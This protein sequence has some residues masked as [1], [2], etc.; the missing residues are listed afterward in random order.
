MRHPI[1]KDRSSKYTLNISQYL[2]LSLSLSVS[3]SV[4]LS[5]CLSVSL[6]L[7]LC[8]Y[9]NFIQMNT[10]ENMIE[11]EEEASSSTSVE[12]RPT[13]HPM[14]NFGGL[15]LSRFANEDMVHVLGLF[16]S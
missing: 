13:T 15:I 12:K 8:N 16:H 14:F 7:S 9:H 3:V 5:L 2:S 4:S 11:E 6:S 10:L 1:G